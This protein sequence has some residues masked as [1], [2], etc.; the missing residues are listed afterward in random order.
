MGRLT[1]IY[2]ILDAETAPP[3]AL[4]REVLAAGVRLIQYRAK[5]GADRPLVRELH[6]LAQAHDAMLV[7]NDDL[8]VALEADGLH[9]GQ[10]DLQRLGAQRV[11]A[12]L[13]GKLF[14]VSCA[15]PLEA[16]AAAALGADYLGAGPLNATASKADAGAAIGAAGL[17]AVVAATS[18]PVAAIGGIELVDLERVVASGASMAAVISAIARAPD[19]AAMARALVARWEM[20]TR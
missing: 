6:A 8:E 4:A 16:R 11:R 12:R 20:L 3:L 9:A 19:R 18:L 10:E 17:R 7:V 15:T 14:G 5:D 1:G 13:A 2:A